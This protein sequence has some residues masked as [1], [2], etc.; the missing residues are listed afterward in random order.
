V[1]RLTKE[2]YDRGFVLNGPTRAPGL[3]YENPETGEQVRVMER[4]ELQRRSD[5]PE[6][7]IFEN[8]YRYRPSINDPFG[9]HVPIPNK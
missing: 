6:K 2:L 1:N 9:S 4:P 8:Y 7:F 3:L 5:P